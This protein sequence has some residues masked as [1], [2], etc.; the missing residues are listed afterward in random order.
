MI[1]GT[2]DKFQATGMMG[3]PVLYAAARNADG[4]RADGKRFNMSYDPAKRVKAD[5]GNER[6]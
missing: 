3:T 5:E 2:D 6:I 1:A 4:S